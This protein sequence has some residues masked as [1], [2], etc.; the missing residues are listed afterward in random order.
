MVDILLH[1]ERNIIVIM[2]KCSNC[3]EIKDLSFFKRNK[4]RYDGLN[5]NCAICEKT[6]RRLYHLNNKEKENAKNRDR[7]RMLYRGEWYQRNKKR[8]L[9]KARIRNKKNPEKHRNWLLK[10]KYGIPLE[11]Y[12]QLLLDQKGGCAICGRIEISVDKRNGKIK[13]LSVD[14]DH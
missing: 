14:L 1:N 5:N 2:K 13:S 8:I 3:H 10:N 12:N 6:R 4:A 9:E 11:Q 7:Q